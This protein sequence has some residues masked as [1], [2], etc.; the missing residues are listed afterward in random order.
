MLLVLLQANIVN[1]LVVSWYLPWDPY[2]DQPQPLDLKRSIFI[3]FSGG[4]YDNTAE[5]FKDSITA[6]AKSD[7]SQGYLEYIH[8]TAYRHVLEQ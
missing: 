1:A 7:S 5:V 2:G 6:I 8:P 4:I 3:G